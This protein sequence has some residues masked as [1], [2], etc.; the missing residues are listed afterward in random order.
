MESE[1]FSNSLI[2][3]RRELKINLL[4][5]KL[6]FVMQDLK[7]GWMSKPT[8]LE[9]LI[10]RIFKSWRTNI[11]SI[12]ELK[13]RFFSQLKLVFC[14]MKAPITLSIWDLNRFLSIA[15]KMPKLLRKSFMRK[16]RM[17][18][19]QSILTSIDFDF[20]WKAFKASIIFV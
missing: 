10:W 19:K 12:I 9:K 14:V 4:S 5:S 7:I 8:I 17:T 15:F 13:Y 2:K 16:L 3:K 11:Y 6:E 18:V 20:K 1:L